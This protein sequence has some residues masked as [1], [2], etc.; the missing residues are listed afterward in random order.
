M[1]KIGLFIF[2]TKPT[3]RIH[4]VRQSGLDQVRTAMKT[5]DRKLT[6]PTSKTHRGS[7]ITHQDV[8]ED[9]A[10]KR[11]WSSKTGILRDNV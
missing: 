8:T 6:P 7:N 4:A 3:T 2:Q 1:G 9:K 5:S 11:A 10:C